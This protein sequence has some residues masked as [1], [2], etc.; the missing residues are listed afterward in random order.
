MKF[1]NIDNFT[2]NSQYLEEIFPGIWLMDDHRW[3]YYVWE[4]VFREYGQQGPFALIH[5]DCHWSGVNDFHGDP[6]AVKRLKEISDLEGIH[7]LVRNNKDVQRD[8]FIVPAI[9][10][11]VVDEVHFYCRQTC[12]GPGLYPPLLRE[13][14]ARQFIHGTMK[15]L[16]SHRISKPI[17]FDIDLDTF[18]RSD[19]WDEGELWPDRE[20]VDFL[21]MCSNLIQ[22]SL[23]VTAAMSFGDSGTEQDTRHLTRLFTS[24]MRDLRV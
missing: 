23:V 12:T 13:H 3:A 19:I 17:I 11:G 18:N 1:P 10:R 8:S 7:S 2:S 21:R 22:S 9:I 14:N 20:I 16:I 5:M 6:A 24:F 4:R 15:S